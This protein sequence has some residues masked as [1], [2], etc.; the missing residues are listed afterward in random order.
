MRLLLTSVRSRHL[1]LAHQS[2]LTACIGARALTDRASKAM[3]ERAAWDFVSDNK[4][5]WDLACINP[6]LV[7]GPIIRQF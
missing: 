4:P 2:L 6:G 1:I 3:A 5:K 7:E